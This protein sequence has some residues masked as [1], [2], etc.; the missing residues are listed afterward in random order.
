[1]SEATELNMGLFYSPRKA[2]RNERGTTEDVANKE[3]NI[4]YRRRNED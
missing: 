1:M 2:R 4:C 3:E